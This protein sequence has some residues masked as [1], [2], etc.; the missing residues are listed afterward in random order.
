KR[1]SSRNVN[2]LLARYR[3]T[4]FKDPFFLP[5]RETSTIDSHVREMLRR[6]RG[7]LYIR[8]VKSMLCT[9]QDKG[10]TPL[11]QENIRLFLASMVRQLS[12]RLQEVVQAIQPLLDSDLRAAT[13]ILGARPDSLNY[14][15]NLGR[16]RIIR[17]VITEV[18]A[19]ATPDK[20]MIRALEEIVGTGSID[21]NQLQQISAELRIHIYKVYPELENKE[22]SFFTDILLERLVS[23]LATTDTNTRG[24]DFDKANPAGRFVQRVGLSNFST[25]STSSQQRLADA[26]AIAACENAFDALPFFTSPQVIDDTWLRLLLDGLAHY[27]SSNG[28]YYK[29]EVVIAPLA[30]WINRGND[31]TEGWKTLLRASL[32]AQE[33]LSQ[34]EED[35]YP[36][37]L[38]INSSPDSI[39]QL[40]QTLIEAEETLKARAYDTSLI[41]GIVEYLQTYYPRYFA[42]KSESVE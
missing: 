24:T 30:E 34:D 42:K 16:D 25:L 39:R 26:L 36:C 40:A 9:Y 12:D 22:S 8:L 5:S 33:R 38:W 2:V 14:L 15:G 21:A 37:I 17:F 4:H 7:D 28:Q 11:T 18:A 10:A 31:L 6:L 23:D 19:E 32:E 13:I 27:F 35:S 3:G 1:G 41:R 29:N 20:L